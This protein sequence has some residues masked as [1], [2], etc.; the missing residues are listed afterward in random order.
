[1]FRGASLNGNGFCTDD[2]FQVNE[3]TG[4][5]APGL[6]EK[7]VIQYLSVYTYYDSSHSVWCSLLLGVVRV[8]SAG[9]NTHPL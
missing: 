7:N 4:C 6:K 1:M 3:H 2:A 9:E 5:S 8:E